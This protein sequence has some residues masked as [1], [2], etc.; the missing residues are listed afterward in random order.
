MTQRAGRLDESSR[1]VPVGRCDDLRK[2]SDTVRRRSDGFSM[3]KSARRTPTPGDS[4]SGAQRHLRQVDPV[5]GRLIERKA[6]LRSSSMAGRPPADGP[7]W[8]PSV[9]GRRSTTFGCGN[10]D[11]PLS[12]SHRSSEDTYPRPRSS[13]RL[14][15]LTCGRRAFMAKGQHACEILRTT[16]RWS[17]GPGTTHRAAGRRFHR[18]TDGG[19]GHRALDRAR[20][21]VR[22]PAKGR[23]CTCPA[24]LLCARRCSMPISSTIC[25]VNRRSS[26]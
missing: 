11:G 15:R 16:L 10:A 26:R 21:V 7:V 23:C 9:S 2:C 6:R 13:W 17:T 12:A 3:T 1:V 25:Q 5:I 8:V 24:I 20:C 22:R 14:H 18:R 4:P 19:S